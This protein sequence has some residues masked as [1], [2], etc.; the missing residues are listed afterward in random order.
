MK[1]MKSFSDYN[2]RSGEYE[3]Y[4]D[5]HV[6]GVTRSWYEILR[7]GIEA[8]VSNVSSSFPEEISLEELDNIDDIIERHD[9]SKFGV[10]EFQPYCNYFYPA[11]GFEKDQAA[12]NK[13]WLHHIHSNKHHWQYYVIVEDEGKLT[14]VDMPFKYICEMICDW[15]SFT[16]RDPSSTALHWWSEN[17]NK[18]TLSE[19]TRH[20]LEVLIDIMSFP[21]KQT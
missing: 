9:M 8:M 18:M 11:D 15:H 12:F 16:L 21:L 2:P 3:D 17:H 5:T 4:I 20:I 19:N 13:A 14:T 1:R 6:E 7:P 10:D